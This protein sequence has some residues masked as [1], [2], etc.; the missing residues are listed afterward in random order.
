[1]AA[2]ADKIVVAGGGTVYAAPVAL[3]TPPTEIDTSPD[4]Q[5]VEFGYVTP[6]G[7]S[8]H[9]EKDTAEVRAWQGAYPVRRT[10]TGRVFVVS[11]GLM[12]WKP[13]TIKAAFGGGDM[14]QT[15]QV[16]TLSGF[17]GTD[18]FKLTWNGTEGGTTFTRG[19]NATEAAIQTALRT[20]TGDTGLTVTGTVDAGPFTV[21]F[22]NPALAYEVTVTSGTG[23]T[24]GATTATKF[25]FVPPTADELYELSFLIDFNDGTRDFRLFIPRATVVDFGEV[26]LRRDEAAVLPLTL[27][28]T[29]DGA[30]YPFTLF[31]DDV[32]FD[33]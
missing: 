12:E 8:F 3:V 21:V 11:F 5:L 13:E 19:T 31:T 14:N 23:G 26:V 9:E 18:A 33:A 17:D 25:A 24:T 7:V 30:S 32:T 4:A 20:A 1:M 22:S 27:N 6:D 28:A 29:S 15:T 16:I 10:V 2:D